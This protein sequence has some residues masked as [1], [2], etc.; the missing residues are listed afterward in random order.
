MKDVYIEN[1][2]A[3]CDRL[4]VPRQLKEENVWIRSILFGLAD[5]TQ[6]KINRTNKNLGGM[7][8]FEE[9][10]SPHGFLISKAR[11]GSFFKDK[12]AE[13]FHDRWFDAEKEGRTLIIAAK[14]ATWAEIEWETSASPK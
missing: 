10:F 6:R 1:L 12:A 9:A 7:L 8:F 2:H 14:Q 5:G 11:I 4:N 3:L 13:H